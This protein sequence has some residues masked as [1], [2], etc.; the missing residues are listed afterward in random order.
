MKNNRVKINANALREACKTRGVKFVDVSQAIGNDDRVVQRM[1]ESGEAEPSVL[2]Q[3]EIALWV[4]PGA[5]TLAKE[6]FQKA[7][8]FRPRCET[9]EWAEWKAKFSEALAEVYRDDK[10]SYYGFCA[11]SLGEINNMMSKT[12]HEKPGDTKK[13]MEQMN[14][15]ISYSSDIYAELKEIKDIFK[16]AWG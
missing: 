15:I 7:N 4:K 3:V 8:D 1:I 13:L 10:D 5:F 2:R 9:E 12:Y 16:K 6:K 14:V 11:A